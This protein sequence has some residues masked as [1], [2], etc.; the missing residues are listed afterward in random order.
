M[1][2]NSDARPFRSVTANARRSQIVAAT[3]EVIA[4]VGYSQASFARISKRAG[5][6]STR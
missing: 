3:I 1:S 6:S 5:L 2:V 4:E